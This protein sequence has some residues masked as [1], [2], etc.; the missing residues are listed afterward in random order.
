MESPDA[1]WSIGVCNPSGLLGKGTLLAGLQSDVIAVSETHLTDVSKSMLS[2]SLRAT[3]PYRFLVTGATLSPRSVASHAG[4]YSGVAVVSKCPSRPLGSCWPLDM[5]ETGRVQVVG[6]F[7]N[8]MWVTGGLLYGY[9]QGKNHPNALE[10][11]TAMLQHLVDHMVHVA[12]GPR[13]LG[14]DWNYLESQLPVTNLLRAR[15]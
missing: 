1:A 7:V 3:S 4:S 13:W 10:R 9:P 11:T 2:T 6:S 14:G 5:Y 15:G 12:V 8:H